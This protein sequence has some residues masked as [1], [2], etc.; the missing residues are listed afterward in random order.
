LCQLGHA[1]WQR[2][3]QMRQTHAA[4]GCQLA[5]RCREIHTD[6]HKQ[7]WSR[8]CC[9]NSCST[10]CSCSNTCCNAVTAT[11]SCGADIQATA[12]A[13]LPSRQCCVC[14]RSLSKHTPYPCDVTN[15]LAELK[16]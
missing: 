11:Q 3:Q 16:G 4:S 15:I 7:G 14:T 12:A 8:L 1:R 13:M 9:R 10:S 2:Q 5:R 6:I